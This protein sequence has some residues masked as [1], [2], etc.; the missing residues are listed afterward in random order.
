MHDTNKK[1]FYLRLGL[2]ELRILN[3]I[4]SMENLKEYNYYKIFNVVKSNDLLLSIA[5]SSLI[6]NMGIIH[7]K[8]LS[9]NPYYRNDKLFIRDFIVHSAS[10]LHSVNVIYRRGL[11]NSRVMNVFKV[12][13]AKNLKLLCIYRTMWM[14]SYESILKRC[15]DPNRKLSIKHVAKNIRTIYDLNN[16]RICPRLEDFNSEIQILFGFILENSVDL[17]FKEKFK[18]LKPSRTVTLNNL[19]TIFRDFDLEGLLDFFTERKQNEPRGSAYFL[20]SLEVKIPLPK[21]L[22]SGIDANLFFIENKSIRNYFFKMCWVGFSGNY[23]QFKQSI[24]LLSKN[25]NIKTEDEE[26]LSKRLKTSE[27]NNHL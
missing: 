12:F 6:E 23:G 27:P 16:K 19:L 11:S 26:P 15:N 3:I 2:G 13:A 21:N 14:S 22:L 9:E 4:N 24:D 10:F 17:K 25:R 1:V 7:L 18:L 5:L 8:L 20:D